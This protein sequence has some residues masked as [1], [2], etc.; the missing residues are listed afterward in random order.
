MPDT[1]QP[2]HPGG[3][4]K[5]IAKTVPKQLT[6]WKPGQSGNPAGRPQGARSKLGEAFIKAMLTDFT[7][8]GNNAIEAVRAD[9]PDQYLKVIAMILPKEIVAEV[10]H[11]FVAL[12]PAPIETTDEWQKQHSPNQRIQ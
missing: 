10:S 4:G 3:N 12:M 5:A 8:H 9:K 6:P 2:K 1:T 7:E 11:R